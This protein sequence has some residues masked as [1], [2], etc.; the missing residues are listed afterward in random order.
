MPMRTATPAKPLVIVIA[1]IDVGN[2]NAL[3]PVAKVALGKGHIVHEFCGEGK[4]FPP[5]RLAE[6]EDVLC[7]A[8]WLVVSLSSNPEKAGMEGDL[9]LFAQLHEVE[10]LIVSDIDGMMHRSRWC[11][12]GA[13]N[14]HTITVT[15]PTEVKWARQYVGP[16]TR[17]VVAQNPSWISY[18]DVTK[19]REDVCSSLGVLTDKRMMVFP[20]DKEEAR[21]KGR[22]ELLVKTTNGLRTPLHIVVT[23]HPNADHKVDVLKQLV[24][25]AQHPITFSLQKETGVSTQDA[26]G[27]C[28]VA[29]MGYGTSNAYVGA[30]LRTP[31][32]CVSTSLEE[33]YWEALSGQQTWAPVEMGI[34]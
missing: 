24:S 12:G 18:F 13:K 20:G 10:V 2:G 14:A 25:G 27:V 30:C 26:L 23:T 17:I 11:H 22:L 16:E 8:D 34:S 3:K 21:N 19:S 28:D 5:E 4:I 31:M 29:V 6:I 7:E 32:I 33:K 1:T 15:S 9:M